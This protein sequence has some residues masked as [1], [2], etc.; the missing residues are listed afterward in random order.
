MNKFLLF[1]LSFLAATALPCPAADGD[2][3]KAYSFVIY[4]A[5]GNRTA[6]LSVEKPRLTIDGTTFRITADG[7][8]TD[9]TAST[10]KRFTLED[11]DGNVLPQSWWLV[12]SLRDGTIEGLP[13]ADRPTITVKDNLFTAT[14]ATRTVSYPAKSIDRFR[15]TDSYDAPKLNGDVNG[16]GAV[17]VAD[18]SAV[19]SVMAGDK[20]YAIRADVNGDSTIDVADIAEVISIMAGGRN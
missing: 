19:I 5:D 8:S 4:T 20:T 15:L 6:Y 12:V 1:V 10:L 11:A 17:D 18:I 16:D 2:G 3:D 14:T 13:F 7:H 9:Y